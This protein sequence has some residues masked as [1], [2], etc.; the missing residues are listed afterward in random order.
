MPNK[1]TRRTFLQAGAATSVLAGL[2]GLSLPSFSEAAEDQGVT[3]KT[4]YNCC[5]RNC[6]DT[7]SI[8]T[9]VE[10]GVIKFVT[11]P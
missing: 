2:G 7:C 11:A 5:P 9:T 1:I 4:C 6:Y 10:D 3:S 8:I